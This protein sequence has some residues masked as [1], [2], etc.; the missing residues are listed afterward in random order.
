MY[1]DDM[2]RWAISLYTQ[3]AE[4]AV[5]I[6]FTFGICNVIVN[7]FLSVAFGGRLKIGGKS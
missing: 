2:V 3:I 6:G 4:L 7:S 5:P 1:P